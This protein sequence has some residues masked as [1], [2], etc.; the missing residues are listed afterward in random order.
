MIKA[1][2]F[3]KDGTLFDFDATWGRWA[4]RA[5]IELAEGDK[6]IEQ[7]LADAFLLNF[8]TSKFDPSSP[9][10]AGTI[11]ETLKAVHA[12]LPNIPQDEIIEK[13][14]EGTEKA[15]L[16]AVCDLPQL[17]TKLSAKY[18]LGI[19]TNDNEASARMHLE[20]A[21]VE[22]F[23]PYVAGWDSGF[24]AKPDHG[25]C[26]AFA[27]HINIAPEN[28]VMIGD[29]TFDLRAGKAAG[30]KTLGVLTGPAPH[31]EL[32]PLADD[33]IASIAGLPEWL[34]SQD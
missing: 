1:L 19:A 29:S 13:M 3:D 33:V 31:E 18:Q 17:F 10:I 22:R 20:R 6:A 8:E 34:E 23:F 27:K 24:G 7:S 26:T 25:M 21:N 2:L 16:V 32:A 30:M 12:V 9:I 4:K 11:D 14:K 5:I 15:E 28:I